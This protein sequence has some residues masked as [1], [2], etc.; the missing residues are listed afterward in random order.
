MDTSKKG[1]FPYYASLKNWIESHWVGLFLIA[2][3]VLISWGSVPALAKLGDLPGGLTTFYVNWFAV[4]ALG[5]I[6]TLTKKWP[7]LWTYSK[8][9]WL[10][11]TGLG[12]VWPFIYSVS[13]FSAI[14]YGSGTTATILNYTWPIFFLLLSWLFYRAKISIA[15]VISVFL[16]VTSVVVCTLYGG[17]G[18]VVITKVALICGIIA[19]ITQAAYSLFGG[20]LR[21][22]PLVVTFVVEVVTAV[23]S[24]V[25]VLFVE[26]SLVLPGMETIFYLA[27]LGVISNGFGFWFFLWGNQISEN[28]P[29]SGR[30]GFLILLSLTPF[31]QVLVLWLVK[32]EPISLGSFVSAA[33][34]LG[35]YL[36][37]RVAHRI[38]D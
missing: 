23:L 34:A 14:K 2:L 27:I 22:D 17:V 19:A 25:Y 8:S 28:S 7:I 37:Y 10:K 16:S 3:V 26:H 18:G 35:S 32:A 30:F 9:D 29:K 20:R 15:S 33:L 12:V 11:I 1:D 13:Y 5:V 4:V 6:L 38:K 21:H 36:I 31:F 24:T